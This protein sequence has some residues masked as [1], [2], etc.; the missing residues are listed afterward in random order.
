MWMGLR[1]SMC[2]RV[3]YVKKCRAVGVAGN[4]LRWVICNSIVGEMLVC[5]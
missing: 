1:S 2:A 3:F 4:V 5:I